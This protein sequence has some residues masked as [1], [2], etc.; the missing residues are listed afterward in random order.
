[1]Y[2]KQKKSK[3]KIVIIAA[4]LLLITAGAGAFYYNKQQ[5]PREAKQAEQD[6]NNT[7]TPVIK[8]EETPVEDPEISNQTT[9]QVPVKEEA[10]LTITKLVQ[11]G[12]MVVLESNATVVGGGGTCVASFTKTDNKPVVREFTAA[13]TACNNNTIPAL[14]FSELGEWHLTLRYYKD[15]AQ[16][17]AEQNLTIN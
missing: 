16:I 9:D 2:L 4:T 3:K 17:V 14:L 10:K 8:N 5:D 11:Q 7:E 12:D 15:G 1:M 13:G 6:K